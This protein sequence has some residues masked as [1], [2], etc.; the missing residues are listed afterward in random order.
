[1]AGLLT[2]FA[3]SAIANTIKLYRAEP[4]P[5]RPGTA[6]RRLSVEQRLVS[7]S[8]LKIVE[9]KSSVAEQ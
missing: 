7:F 6:V 1:M 8:E 4:L 5:A 2:T 3:A 9:S